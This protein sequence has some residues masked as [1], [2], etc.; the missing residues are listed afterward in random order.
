VK[1]EDSPVGVANGELIRLT[2]RERRMATGHTVWISFAE[3]DVWR[4][5][6][7]GPAPRDHVD[8]M[9][10]ARCPLCGDWR[11]WERF[12]EPLSDSGWSEGQM[13]E[14][15]A[16]NWGTAY[17]GNCGLVLEWDP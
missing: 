13:G 17:C 1:G 3:W 8:L 11:T 4:N 16:G 9:P 7:W 15:L 12:A 6:K 10:V 14:W 2:D 5:V